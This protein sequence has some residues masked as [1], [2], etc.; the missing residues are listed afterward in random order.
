MNKRK[1]IAALPVGVHRANDGKGYEAVVLERRGFVRLG[2]FVSKRAAVA[3]RR[4]YWKE[5]AA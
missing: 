2:V 3:A 4:K 5:R 1:K